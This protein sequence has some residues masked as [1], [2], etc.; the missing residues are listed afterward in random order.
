MGIVKII[1]YIFNI[2]IQPTSDI[3]ARFNH[4]MYMYTIL[5]R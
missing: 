3:V 2:I 4:E 5:S 1:E